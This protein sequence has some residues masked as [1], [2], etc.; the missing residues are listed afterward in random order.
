MKS[1][2]I[3]TKEAER[4]F[5]EQIEILEEIWS[6]KSLRKFIDRVFEV[7]ELIEKHPQL[8]PVFDIKKQIRSCVINQYITLFYKIKKDQIDLLLF[9]P[10]RRDPESL[11]L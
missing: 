11:N 3:W 4:S 8:Y 1:R 10:N 6:E 5:N 7:I 2:V 9:W